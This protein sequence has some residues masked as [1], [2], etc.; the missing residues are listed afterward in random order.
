[1]SLILNLI[2]VAFSVY[3][4]YR[5]FQLSGRGRLNKE[6]LKILDKMDDRD[7]FFA[8]A[9]EFIEVSKDPE[10]VQKVSVLRLWGDVFYERDEEYKQ[11][12]AELDIDTLLQPMQKNRGFANNEDS[13]FYLYLA[14]PNRLNFRGRNDLR[15]LNDEKLAAYEEINGD[16]LLKKIHDENKKFYEHTEDC[17]KDF[18]V[19]LLAGEYAG[20]RYSKQLIGL[21]K[22]CEEAILAVLYREE[23]N[24]EG[25]EE[26]LENVKNF[27]TNTRLGIRWLKELGI[28]LPN[29]EE[30]TEEAEPAEEAAEPAEA[31]ETPAEEVPAEEKDDAE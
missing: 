1:M 25:Y 13:F 23:G 11:H 31:E 22:H 6:M 15:K 27:G 29:E 14:I 21:Y 20:Y 8:R 2:L 3:M 10:Y 28:E 16:T 9:D 5:V 7:E 18:I 26:C 24:T 17:G 12:L 4:F 30:E 19:S